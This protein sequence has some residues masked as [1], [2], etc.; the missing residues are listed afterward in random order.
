MTKFLDGYNVKKPNKQ[1]V[2]KLKIM[3]LEMT[4]FVTNSKRI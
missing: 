2:V 4:F 1:N 3:F